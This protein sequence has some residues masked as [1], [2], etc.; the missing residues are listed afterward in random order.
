[1]STFG[2]GNDIN[3]TILAMR[4]YGFPV[5][6][7]TWYLY[8][9]RS[10]LVPVPQPRALASRRETLITTRRLFVCC[11]SSTNTNLHLAVS[12]GQLL[13]GI[14]YVCIHLRRTL[15]MDYADSWDVVPRHYRVVSSLTSVHWEEQT[16]YSKSRVS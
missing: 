1:M 8:T 16:R 12:N 3:I 11:I 5:Q 4:D 2:D 10:A 14:L 15:I 6:R 7:V 9:E 13:R